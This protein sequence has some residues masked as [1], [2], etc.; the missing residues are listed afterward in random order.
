MGEGGVDFCGRASYSG[1]LQEL[2]KNPSSVVVMDPLDE[3][4]T[5]VE[6]VEHS[7]PKMHKRKKQEAAAAERVLMHD[8]IVA[9]RV[10]LDLRHSR[11]ESASFR[12][13]C[14]CFCAFQVCR[15][16]NS[17]LFFFPSFSVPDMSFDRERVAASRP[18]LDEVFKPAFMKGLARVDGVGI[19]LS[20]PNQEVPE[21]FQNVL[22]KIGALPRTVIFL[23]LET[24]E[25]PRVKD[26]SKIRVELYSKYFARVKLR[27][28]YIEK[29]VDYGGFLDQL[30]QTP[31][32]FFP[33]DAPVTWF[34]GREHV[35]VSKG[36]CMPLHSADLVL[37]SV[38]DF[39]PTPML[40]S[41]LTCNF[42]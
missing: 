8:R 31:R 25:K 26:T 39:F 4:A 35:Y 37:I 19:F 38:C 40:N 18:S 11:T 10:S 3:N 29:K 13:F 12:N 7:S 30:S 1:V 16:S 20:G 9:A 32:L 41:S 21:V 27:K 28:G 17:S 2:V 23:D 15:N 14:F 33:E 5:P 42:S 6:E 22:R 34:M 24:V 36:A